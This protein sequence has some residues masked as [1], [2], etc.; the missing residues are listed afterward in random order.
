MTELIRWLTIRGA[1]RWLSVSEPTI[2][3]WLNDGVFQAYRANPRGRILIK[4]SDI[5]EAMEKR[6]LVPRAW[7]KG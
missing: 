2:R 7:G 5:V 1:A 6:R 4:A 3:N